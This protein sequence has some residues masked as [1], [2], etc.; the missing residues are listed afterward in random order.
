MRWICLGSAA[1]RAGPF[2]VCL[3]Q[4]SQSYWINSSGV[5]T[6]QP[7]LPWEWDINAICYVR[8]EFW[9]IF[10]I[11]PHFLIS[12][13]FGLLCICNLFEIFLDRHT[14]S[15]AVIHLLFYAVYIL[16]TD[17]SLYLSAKKEKQKNKT[18]SFVWPYSDP[19][20]VCVCVCVWGILE[21]M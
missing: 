4:F 15:F 19:V 3:K 5:D 7:R 6:E 9:T 18:L 2:S 17:F 10:W 1:G 8:H 12:L 11:I 16:Q 21:Q 13:P 14:L 20:C